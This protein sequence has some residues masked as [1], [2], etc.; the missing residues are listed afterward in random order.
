MDRRTQELVASNLG[1]N[2]SLINAIVSEITD[3]RDQVLY[4][5]QAEVSLELAM[6][7]L[8]P[9]RNTQRI[10]VEKGYGAQFNAQYDCAGAQEQ[11]KIAL[12]FIGGAK[13]FK[14]PMLRRLEDLEAAIQHLSQF[15]EKRPPD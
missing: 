7:F 13:A 5:S 15:F 1:H 10:V 3:C 4:L 11:L 2:R 8:L 12:E 14:G 6:E 9:P